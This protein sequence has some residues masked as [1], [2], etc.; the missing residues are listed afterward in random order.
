MLRCVC[1][2]RDMDRVSNGIMTEIEKVGELYKKVQERRLKWYGHVVTRNEEYV[3]KRATR[4]D[5]EGRRKGRPKQ[6]WMG[7]V[8]VDLREK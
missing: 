4:V 3:G 5:V 2:V 8:P 6:R 7:S 1:G